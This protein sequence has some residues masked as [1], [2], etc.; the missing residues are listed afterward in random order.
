MDGAP[1]DPLTHVPTAG[2]T[3]ATGQDVARGVEIGRTKS[4][5]GVSVLWWSSRTLR[6][7]Q[8]RLRQLR[9]P[10]ALTQPLRADDLPDYVLVIESGELLRIMRDAREDLHDTVFLEIPGGATLDLSS[11]R[12]IEGSDE[13]DARVEF[14]FPRQVGGRPTLDSN[15]ESIVF[16]CKASAKNP[17]PGRQNAV[18]L[19]AE[20]APRRMR[21]HGQPDL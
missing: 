15:L 8:Q 17:R 1:L 10:P 12:F 20:F 21:S 2:L 7:A 18:S 4:L 14:H 3:N 13:G 9:N 11:A 16:H 6:L 5:P 19:R